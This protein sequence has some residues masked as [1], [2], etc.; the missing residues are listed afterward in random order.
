MKKTAIALI[1]LALAS[2]KPPTKPWIIVAK[3][4]NSGMYSEGYC[5]FYYESQDGRDGT[6]CDYEEMYN[7]GDTI[8]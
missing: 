3:Y 1:L 8:K 7:V 4:P 2:C 5:R 6:F